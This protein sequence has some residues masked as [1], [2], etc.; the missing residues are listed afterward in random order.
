MHA[1]QSVKRT[2]YKTVFRKLLDRFMLIE[3]RV[4]A[5]EKT[6]GRLKKQ[7]K[8]ATKDSNAVQVTELSI[9][10]TQLRSLLE[11]SRSLPPIPPGHLQLRVSGAH[12]PQFFE[13]GEALLRG[14]ESLLGRHGRDIR[15][16]ESILDFG[17]GCGRILIPLMLRKN[18]A[19]LYGCDIDPEAIAWCKSNLTSCAGFAVNDPFPPMQFADNQFDLIYGVSVF[20]HLP[21][22]MQFKWLNELFRVTRPGGYAIMTFHGEPHYGALPPFA[23]EKL[24]NHGFFYS[25]HKHGSTGGLPDFYQTTWHTHGYIRK[26]WGEKFELVDIVEGAIANHGSAILRKPA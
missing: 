16:F 25:D 10:L 11:L 15:S 14:I 5:L 3:S 4:T 7:L 23:R 22:E 17:C 18:A 8:G 9:Q 20:T 2:V 24:E 19:R 21:E 6:T 26:H 13:Q 1:I 12:S